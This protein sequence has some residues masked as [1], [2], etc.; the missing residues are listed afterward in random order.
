MPFNQYSLTKRGN[1]R[2]SVYSLTGQLIET[3]VDME[4]APGNYT[5]TFDA[6]EY[7]SGVYFYKLETP[8][9]QN[10]KRLILMR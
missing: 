1:V 8:G 7:A 10:T 3:L 2:L 5:L 9:F 4:Q 6:K